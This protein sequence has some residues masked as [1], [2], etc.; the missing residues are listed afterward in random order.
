MKKR[1]VSF[2]WR[3]KT[4]VFWKIQ[5]QVFCLEGKEL[6]HA[7]K[8]AWEIFC[9]KKPFKRRW[10][11]SMWIRVAFLRYHGEGLFLL[12][13]CKRSQEIRMKAHTIPPMSEQLPSINHVNPPWLW[14]L[15][16]TYQWKGVKYLLE[17]GLRF[18]IINSVLGPSKMMIYHGCVFK[19][20]IKKCCLC[21][22]AL[23]QTFWWGK[24]IYK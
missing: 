17:W 11:R 24:N 8:G 3:E 21:Y 23:K 16:F 10:N 19:V 22:Y 13:T 14:A 4:V 7:E 6:P 5:D 12:M 20:E 18:M 15:A 2:L 1:D 9:G